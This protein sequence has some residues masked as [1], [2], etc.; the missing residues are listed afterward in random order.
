MTETILAVIQVLFLGGLIWQYYD[1]RYLA[2]K[3]EIKRRQEWASGIIEELKKTDSVI[4][5][6][7]NEQSIKVSKFLEEQ[8]VQKGFDN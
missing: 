6:H 5:I 1:S 7:P 2:P 4:V 3:R 8:Q